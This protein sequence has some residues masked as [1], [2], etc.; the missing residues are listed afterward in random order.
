M[1][2]KIIVFYSWQSDLPKETNLNGIRQSLRISA[3][4]VEN[5]IK[6][7][8]VKLDE[9]TR[10]KAGSPNIPF[11]I[12]EKISK[13]DIFIC[14]LTTINSSDTKNRKVSNPNVLIE[15]GYAVAELGWE[16]IILLFNKAF[17]TFPQDLPFDIDRHRTTPFCIIDKNDKSGK[18]QLSQILK[19]ALA[20]IIEQKPLKKIDA[21]KISP[22]VKKRNIDIANLKWCLKYV[23]IPTMDY[24]LEEMPS[25][26][27]K[28]IFHYQQGFREVVESSSFHIYNK[29]L[30]S[31]ITELNKNWSISLAYGHQY[32]PDR[33][34]NY[35]KYYAPSD[36]FPND[37]SQ[38]EY[39]YLL[40]IREKLIEVFKSFLL[41]IRTEY[42]E[43]DLDTTSKI[44][45]EIYQ[46]EI[47]DD[48]RDSE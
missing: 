1:D 44:A 18:A 34:G 27:I 40:K 26:I 6:D 29:E 37:K 48:N 19:G 4:E 42:L 30:M 23:H 28:H 15:L 36:I 33:F 12:F 17:G 14:D 5:S 10:D 46:K 8:S 2:K 13:A 24:F 7:I 38:Q 32:D 35:Y 47:T 45:F 11:T 9:A 31:L 22:E 20:T 41:Y 16:R 43:I 3:N 25:R 39:N 21:K